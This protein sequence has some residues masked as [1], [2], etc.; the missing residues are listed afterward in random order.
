MPLQLGQ[1]KFMELADV[2]IAKL[3][4]DSASAPTYDTLVDLAGALSL[5][6]QP[7]IETKQ[8][9]GDSETKDI[10]SKV[11]E[12]NVEGEC[13]MANI[14]AYKVMVGGSVTQTGE[15]PNQKATWKLTSATATLPYFKIEGQWTYAGEG[16]GD[17]HVVVYKMKVTEPPGFEI[18]DASGNFG[19][20]KFKGIAVPTTSNGDWIDA[21]FNETRTNILDE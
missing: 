17:A 7:V 2:K 14:E 5:T 18:N 6:V 19:T 9:K 10:Y 15:T 1:V 21:V 11:V 4:T 12:V 16:I 8:L 20:F 3:L 13:S